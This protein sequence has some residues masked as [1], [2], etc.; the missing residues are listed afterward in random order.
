MSRRGLD[1]ALAFVAFAVAAFPFSANAAVHGIIV[2]FNDYA[3]AQKL[4]GAVADANDIAAVLKKRGASDLVLMTDPHTTVATFRSRWTE[5]VAR[6]KPGDLILFSFSGHGMRLP[7]T[8][9]PRRTP[10]GYDKGFLFPTFDQNDRPDEILRDEDLYDLFQA[11]AAKGLRILFVVDACHA[12]TA[13]RRIDSRRGGGAVKFQ[14]FDVRPETPP[15]VPPKTPAPPRPPLPNVAAI[16]AQLSEK[17][18]Q[19]IQI[20]GQLRGALSYAVARGLEGAADPD[21]SGTITLDRLWAYVRNVV[22]TRSENM[23]APVL[24]A[25]DQDGGLLL[26]STD[27]TLPTPTRLQETLPD[28]GTIALFRIGSDVTPQGAAIVEDRSKA[29]LIFDMARHQIL[30][31]AGDVLASDIDATRLQGAVDA[32]RL[33]SF[34]RKAAERRGG[35][36]VEVRGENTPS[37]TSDDRIYQDGNRVRFEAEPGNFE[38]LTVF[39][40][41]SDGTVQFLYPRVD[42]GD[43]L[44]TSSPT[45]LQ[46]ILVQHPFGADYAIFVRSDTPLSELHAMFARTKDYVSSAPQT[47]DMLRQAL[48]GARFRIGIQ[49][50]YTCHRIQEN[51]QCDSMI[52]SP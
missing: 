31:A 3:R 2:G 12:G 16:T 13:L 33:L 21:G 37:G 43:P 4:Q 34:L 46:S 19:E 49:G 39:D 24:F 36:T 42:L 20:D 32:R 26:L 47:Y 48:R 44:A 41:T 40:V 28:P 15:V 38:F 10:D 14:H 17:T 8:R 52:A 6:A 11:T 25:R 22:R 35:L 18:I 27:G 45:P 9:E 29:D 50:L 7:E 51:G 1:V 30:D 5:I 23:Q